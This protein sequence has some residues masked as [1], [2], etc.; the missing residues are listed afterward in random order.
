MSKPSP[1]LPKPA[2]DFYS[3]EPSSFAPYLSASSDTSSFV[4]NAHFGVYRV[5]LDGQ[6][7]NA[8]LALARLNGYDSVNELLESLGNIASEWYVRPERR[9]EFFEL[10]DRQGYAKNFESEVYRHKTRERVWVSEDGWLVRDRQGRPLY[11]EGTILDITARKEHEL[12]QTSLAAM[13][14]E[15]LRLGPGEAFYQALLER[16]VH[17]IPGAQ[18]GSILLFDT[19][20]GRYRY[21]ATAGF[22]LGTLSEV[23]FSPADMPR[24]H[25]ARTPFVIL[26][27]TV[28][29]HF[30]GDYLDK[31]ETHGRLQD[32]RATL[33]IPIVLGEQPLAI[34]NLDNFER[35]DAFDTA[36]HLADTL[37]K[38]LVNVLGR[39]QLESVIQE[40]QE[41]LEQSAS[42][43][44]SLVEFMSA[45]LK[46]GQGQDFYARLL[47][48][49]VGVVPGAQAGSI[50]LKRGERYH[51][52]ATEGF[53][54]EQLAS[55]S[56][57][58]EELN[59]YQQEPYRLIPREA[60]IVRDPER[61]AVLD[62]AGRVKD[63][64]VSLTI[65]ISNAGDVVAFLF[66]DNF[67]SS[68]A[69]SD[70]AIAMSRIFAEQIGVLLS[71]FALERSLGNKQQDLKQWGEFHQGLT[72]LMSDSL[73]QGLDENFYQRL[74][75]RAVS[76]VPGAQMGSIM[77]RNAAANYQFVASVGFDL[78]VL[79]TIVL[80]DD[81]LFLDSHNPAPQLVSHSP[82]YRSRNEHTQDVLVTSGK[83]Y[84]IVVTLAIPIWIDNSLTA[85]LF[86][87]NLEDDQA[88]HTDAVQMAEGFAKQ[89]GILLKRLSLEQELR[90]R[91]E[92]LER[93]EKFR[94][95]LILFISD[96]LKR[97]LDER[98]YQR[99]LE[100][101]AS[102]IPGAKAGSIM[103]QRG[104]GRYAFVAA[105]GHDLTILREVTFAPHEVFAIQDE[106][107]AQI[108]NGVSEKNL[109]VLDAGRSASL[110]RASYGN[111]IRS[112]LAVPVILE[113]AVVASLSLDAYEDDAFSDEA[114]E[115]ASAFGTQVGSLLQRL[116]LEQELQERQQALSRWSS[117]H[118]SLIQFSNEALRRGE[119]TTFYQD[120]LEHAASVIPGVEAGSVLQRDAHGNYRFVSSLNFDLA[121][122]QRLTLSSEELYYNRN[123]RPDGGH[124]DVYQDA[125]VYLD[126]NVSFADE[127]SYVRHFLGAEHL[128]ILEQSGRIHDIGST[129]SAA[130][131]I[132][133]AVVAVLN[134][135]AFRRQAFSSESKDM[136]R[137]Y[138]AQIAVLLQR[139]TLE[140]ALEKSNLELAKLAN[141]DAL[142]GLPNRALFADRL[143]QAIAKSSRQDAF[144]ALIFLDLDGFK[145]INDSLGHSVGDELLKSVAERLAGCVRDDD[146]VARLGGDEFT[147]ILNAL[148]APH[149][150]VYVAEKV[151]HTL[152]KPFL[153]DGR[154]LHIGASIGITVYPDD[155]GSVEE[156]VQHADTAMYHAKA[157]G[158]NRYHFFT[159]ELNAKA[160]EQLRLENDMRR[161]LERGE[162]SLVYQPRVQLRSNDVTSLEALARWQHPELGAIS[163][164]VFIPVAEK[165]NFIQ[166]LGR[167]VLR[168]A[169]MQAKSWQEQGHVLR[170]AVNVSV[171]QL[172][173]GTL[174]EDVQ[175]VL[176][177]T[178]LAAQWLE[179]E[180]TES[181]AMTDVESNIGTLK[182]LRDM[183]IYIS[184]DDFGTAYSSLNYLKRLPVNSLKIDKSFVEDISDTE[185]ADTAIV[186][187]VIALGK[188]LGFSLIAEGVED[189]EQLSFLRG[190][191][192]DEAQ[193][194][195]FSKPMTAADT[196]EWIRAQSFLKRH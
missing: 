68:Q 160:T 113:G 161:G 169:C 174:I 2:P 36:L 137:A 48:E 5:A 147:I 51:F 108:I 1:D 55:V 64:K 132:D 168:Q 61:R 171:K 85:L 50:L 34:I 178:G 189:T 119:T 145:L 177:E 114:L 195:W 131:M 95:S 134:L 39:F 89:V 44:H 93:W 162:F 14:E 53:D 26:P 109:D 43:H 27:Q 88:F 10:L 16:A 80:S 90:C 196:A 6:P 52:V 122:L 41:V 59:A 107:R 133:G 105:V 91:Q 62:T 127:K 24:K 101:A 18:A 81:D 49:A 159:S 74:L 29:P 65:P 25:G 141:Y 170:V 136:A 77:L 3:E 86:L 143:A 31:L 153:L 20:L 70:S 121:A 21:V 56:F 181:A 180:I 42:F 176:M 66:L 187:A 115:M 96:T 112:L 79:Q 84:A 15:T 167:E 158:K 185:S 40:R 73:Q 82:E 46:Q 163:P 45:S 98:F 97:G 146:T 67:E 172:Q 54:G 116:K 19:R 38:Q 123:R 111:T 32:I 156:L 151:L 106:P 192:C 148:K 118:S 139:L 12:F 37:S 120:I 11:Y 92:A 135:N 9:R 190:A 142:T 194:Y 71:R 149:D 103:T 35:S 23:S 138:A 47:H 72:Q 186:Q 60:P 140:H 179:L 7:L 22:D 130:V 99:L 188:S 63:I 193:G 175:K 173:Q 78:A 83:L 144:T 157:L 150:T 30:G 87:D 183:G 57:S 8:N 94:S 166:L 76:V 184:I 152:S 182:T 58:L 110:Q 17:S 165:S 164:G 117:F 75:E 154:E 33:N 104:D 191:G 13:I 128:T 102:V 4:D 129:L 125:D 126:N 69:F 124:A 155:G 100:H 28:K